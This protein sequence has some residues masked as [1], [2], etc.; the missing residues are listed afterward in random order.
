MADD[1]GL[2]DSAAPLMDHLV[3]LRRRLLISL[4]A[5]A[6]AFIAAFT[7]ADRIFGFLVQPLVDAFGGR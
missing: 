7:Q 3:E 2:D 1:E 5:L 4:A 6:V